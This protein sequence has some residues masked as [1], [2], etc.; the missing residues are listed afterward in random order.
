MPY[1]RN[2]KIKKNGITSTRYWVQV[3]VRPRQRSL[4]SQQ[5]INYYQIMR[6]TGG[7][8]SRQA[9]RQ[10]G[11]QIINFINITRKNIAMDAIETNQG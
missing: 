1:I 9:G 10:A 2:T 8:A 11:R 6:T 5:T 7:Q 3:Q 4:A